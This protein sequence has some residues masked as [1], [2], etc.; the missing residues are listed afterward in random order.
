MPNDDGT[1]DWADRLVELSRTVEA[2]DELEIPT[3][4]KLVDPNAEAYIK[5][6]WQLGFL[7]GLQEAA[8]IIDEEEV[9]IT[10]DM[11]K[12][13]AEHHAAK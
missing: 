7:A 11:L 13:A 12:G 8:T 10:M 6:I 2:P 3:A 1:P 5:C 9:H 4:F